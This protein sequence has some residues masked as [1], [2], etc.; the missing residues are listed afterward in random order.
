VANA[1]HT[2]AE[3][4]KLLKPLGVKTRFAIHPVA[5]RMPGQLNVLLAE[6]G[7]PYDGATRRALLF[8]RAVPSPLAL[9]LLP[10]P[11]FL[12]LLPFTLLFA[13]LFHA[14]LHHSSPSFFTLRLSTRTRDPLN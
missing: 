6:A 12:T 5:G 4:Y 7:V 8:V 14:K 2:V 9:A 10:W 11:S 3:L 1:Q 13:T